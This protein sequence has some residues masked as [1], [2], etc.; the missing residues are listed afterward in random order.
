ME[1]GD[2]FFLEPIKFVANKQKS[3][4]LC[5]ENKSPRPL[6]IV[7]SSMCLQFWMMSLV[8]EVEKGSVMAIM[9]TPPVEAQNSACSWT[10]TCF[11]ATI[12][13]GNSWPWLSSP[14]PCGTVVFCPLWLESTTRVLRS[15]HF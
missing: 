2:N 12:S 8:V 6:V 13:L 9:G 3:V 15:W 14:F 11:S 10:L 4:L 1:K 7:L 5:T